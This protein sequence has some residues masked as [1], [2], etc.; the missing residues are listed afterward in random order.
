MTMNTDDYTKS[1]EAVMAQERELVC[2]V[3]LRAESY[4]YLFDLWCKA[5]PEAL[6]EMEDIA[7]AINARGGRVSAKYLIE[8]LRYEG[9]ARLHAVPYR[10]Q[11]GMARFYNIHN[12]LTPLIARW[13]VGRHPS[14]NVQLKKSM[15]DTVAFETGK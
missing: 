8:R 15:F 1:L 10:D 2:S 5:N 4:V 3:P 12:T 7:V 11:Y 14:M 9:K 6:R 13:L